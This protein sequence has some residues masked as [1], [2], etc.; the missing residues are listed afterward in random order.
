MG[1]SSKKALSPKD[2]EERLGLWLD[3]DL[4][5]KHLKQ[6]TVFSQHM[7]VSTDRLLHFADLALGSIKPDK[8]KAEKVSKKR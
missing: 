8:F 7:P 2:R 1:A 6:H 5:D 3:T 4:I